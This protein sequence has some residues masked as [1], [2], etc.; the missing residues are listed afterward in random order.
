[1]PAEIST[2]KALTKHNRISDLPASQDAYASLEANL[3]LYLAKN[4]LEKVP[5]AVLE[6]DNLR[7]LSLRNNALTRIPSGI[8]RLVNLQTLN[9]AG[10]KL[11]YLPFEIVELLQHHTLTTLFAD[12]NPWEELDE[13][14][15]ELRPSTQEDL[16]HRPHYVRV[17][18]GDPTFYRANGTRYVE[19][20]V[21]L[22]RQMTKS[23]VPSLSELVL[24]H[25]CNLPG[26][27]SVDDA[28]I[29]DLPETAQRMLIEA[30][31]A[32]SEGG[33]RCTKC[34]GEMVMPRKQWMEWWTVEGGLQ[35][36]GNSFG[37]S[38]PFLRQ[39]CHDRCNGDANA[40]TDE[41]ALGC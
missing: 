20:R 11:T 33:R 34:H 25:L 10:N 12:P 22:S 39:Q 6:L 17:H 28:V 3:R 32:Q 19:S 24:R 29:E 31:E 18:A 2:L 1:M 23:K 35:S 37:W 14:F 41:H 5:L 27:S 13:G 15:N 9:V 4:L 7:L 38:I 30:Q 36:S 21:P 40:W 8:R 26:I 16:V